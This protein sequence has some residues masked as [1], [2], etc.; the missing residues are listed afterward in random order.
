MAMSGRIMAHLVVA[1]VVASLAT[2]AGA[3]V[4]KV[5]N[6]L[7]S[8]PGSLR[9]AMED[10]NDGSSLE[11]HAIEFEIPSDLCDD[12]GCVIQVASELPHLYNMV[13]IDGFSQPLVDPGDPSL[14]VIE[15]VAGITGTGGLMFR[16]SE[17][18]LWRINVRGFTDTDSAISFKDAEGFVM[19][20]C[21]VGTD[22]LGDAAVPNSIGVE[23]DNASSVQIVDNVL[24]GNA[25]DAITVLGLASGV[26]LY[27]N[28][29]GLTATGNG[30]LGNGG[31]GVEIKH[32][33]D[34]VVG[35]LS[36]GMGNFIAHNGQQ[37]IEISDDSARNTVR[38]NSLYGNEGVSWTDGPE[39]R[40]VTPRPSGMTRSTPQS[41]IARRSRTWLTTSSRASVTCSPGS[42]TSSSE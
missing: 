14:I 5:V 37:G 28:R 33:T 29:I 13:V 42:T 17:S 35:G 24:S 20:E 38:G 36:A 34:C 4:F 11:Q 30:A 1:L 32:G 19:E 31:D 16:A 41:R 9:Q 12:D 27:G 6:L 39:K 7:D 21:Y 10:V 18:G 22:R 2:P 23:I 26:E 40:R 8:G 15:G 3:A 25:D